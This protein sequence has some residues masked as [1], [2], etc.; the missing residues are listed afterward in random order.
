L[1]TVEIFV[2]FCVNADIQIP[3]A[4]QLATQASTIPSVLNFPLPKSLEFRIRPLHLFSFLFILAFA[5]MASET[6]VTA[7]ATTA[8]ASAPP[9]PPLDAPTA[10]AADRVDATAGNA[11]FK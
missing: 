3:E 7:T 4:R 1:S 2:N 5:Y 9:R 11:R 10:S 6:D 8:T